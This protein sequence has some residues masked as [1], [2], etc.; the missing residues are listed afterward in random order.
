MIDVDLT[1]IPRD[2][3]A[4]LLDSWSRRFQGYEESH[5]KKPS[6]YTTGFINAMDIMISELD[7]LLLKN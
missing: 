4:N 3:L 7:E 2:V 6:D 1:D 5:R